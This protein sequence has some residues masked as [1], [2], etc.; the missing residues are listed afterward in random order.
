GKD[1]AA[2]TAGSSHGPW[3][4]AQSPALTFAL[5]NAY[6]AGLGLPPLVVSSSLNPPNRRMRTRMS[7]GVAGEAG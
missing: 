7:G 3:R 1:R 2:Q 4:L 6:Y 5:P